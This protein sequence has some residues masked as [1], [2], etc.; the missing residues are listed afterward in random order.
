MLAG[1]FLPE[2]FFFAERGFAGGQVYFLSDW[3]ST[4]EEQR[5]TVTRLEHQRVPIVVLES[6]ESVLT[7]FFVVG[8]HLKAHY[9]TVAKSAFGGEQEY[10]VLVDSRLPAG[11][12]YE[13]LDLPCYR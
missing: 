10:T 4:V 13:P 11:K 12:L 3:H 9:K 7:N 6:P 5:L 1:E 8:D 2:L